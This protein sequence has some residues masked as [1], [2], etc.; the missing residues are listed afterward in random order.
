MARQ[1]TS[2]RI[3]LIAAASAVRDELRRVLTAGGEGLAGERRIEWPTLADL[4]IDVAG[5]LKEGLDL[6]RHEGSE[7]PYALAV[8]DA[9]AC[10][11]LESAAGIRRLREF[12]Q[13]L[14]LVVVADARTRSEWITAL[15][16][17]E[18]T[19]MV[20]RPFHGF[21][22]RQLAAA[23]I[24]AHGARRAVA[25]V[26]RQLAAARHEVD[27]RRK[28][29]EEANH[30]KSHFMANVSHEIRTPLNAILG[31]SR[32]L[33]REPLAPHQLE[34]LR[35]VH[36][37]GSA[38]LAIVDDVLDF[39]RLAAGKFVLRPVQFSLEEVFRE[40][41]AAIRSSAE[42]KGIELLLRVDPTVPVNLEGDVSQLRQILLKLVDNAI[43]FTERGSV[44]VRA[45]L[46]EQT[47]DE[48]RV[49]L[50]VTDTGVGIPAD[51]QL[52]IFEAFRQ[53][54]GSNTRR[55]GGLGLGLT[56]VKELTDLMQGQVGFTSAADQGSSFWVT[57][58]LKQVP[59]SDSE[60]ARFLPTAVEV[61]AAAMTAVEVE[62]AGQANQGENRPRI[63]VAEDDRL[64]RTLLEAVLVKLGCTVDLVE[65]GRDALAAARQDRYDLIFMDVQMPKM[66]GLT[67]IQRI[68]RREHGGAR[69]PIVVLT[70]MVR[71]EDRQR[72]LLA[73]ADEFVTK[74]FTA[75]FIARVLGRHVRSWSHPGQDRQ[76]AGERDSEATAVRLRQALRQGAFPIVESLAGESRQR[77]LRLQLG[78]AAD[79]AMRVQ[80]AAR[81]RDPRRAASAIDKL[82]FALRSAA[83]E[84]RCPNATVHS[85]PVAAA[86]L[87]EVAEP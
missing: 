83:A 69:V 77:A 82:D 15:A 57:V 87:E 66:D 8:I 18:R 75:E 60:P 40:I 64:N 59:Q 49:R 68:R 23:L 84:W 17:L 33:M 52:V 34:K 71:S 65:N 74:P 5:G 45:V 44:Q 41:E 47:A 38:L 24:D 61:A 9:P 12:H 81:A 58:P 78:E 14:P 7:A 35:Y 76:R 42:S 20:T 80:M 36:D 3:L 6:M 79:H 19:A 13:A 55:Y 63:L 28:E 2:H 51:R 10:D 54:D 29:A 70:A 43:K 1:P 72:C 31:F 50:S 21:E 30:V 46:E 62:S 48:A 27:A 26:Q 11:V 85:S 4:Q 16:P 53:A 67:A 25:D 39:S 22:M 56:I 37:A 73:G 32:L 86:V